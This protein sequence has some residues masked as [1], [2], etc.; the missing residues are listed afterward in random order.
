MKGCFSYDEI[1]LYGAEIVSAIDYLHSKGIIHRDM[2]PENI[3]LDESGHIKITDFGLSK[4]NMNDSETR[5]NSFVGT[6][7]YMAP[8]I[9]NGEKQTKAIDWW[10][11]GYIFN[12]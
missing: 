3:L 8:E 4:S 10:S 1:R 9:I 2:K 5:A 11:L 6:L 12:L 7:H